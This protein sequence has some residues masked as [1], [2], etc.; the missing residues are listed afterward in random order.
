MFVR[1]EIL[2]K[3]ARD[4]FNPSEKSRPSMKTISGTTPQSST[5]KRTG[6]PGSILLIAYVG[7]ILF[8]LLLGGFSRAEAQDDSFD[9]EK[10]NLDEVKQGELLF[11]H[12]QLATFSKASLLSQ[13]VSISI[14]GMA[15]DVS[16][17]QRFQN[18]TA[19]WLEAI[20]VF[21]LPEQSAVTGMR[22]TIGD[23][24]VV[25]RI[26][27]KELARRTYDQ[28][29]Q[30]GKKTSL[31]VRQRPNIFT[32]AVANI[33][34]GG[35]IEVTMEYVDEL[36]FDNDLFTFRFPMVVGPRYIPGTPVSSG[37]GRI[38]FDGGGWA[39]DT[40]QVQDGSR[41]TPPVVPPHEPARNPVELSLSLAPGFAV[42]DLT[43]LYH[44]V[45]QTKKEK[46]TYH[47]AF[48]GTV[49]ADR[50]FVVQYRAADSK[51]IGAALF[52]DNAAGDHFAYLMLMPPSVQMVQGKSTAPR[53][54][55]FILDISGSMA[56]SSLRQAKSAVQY[57][58]SRLQ[59]RD[60]FNIIV[61]NN[62]ARKLYPDPLQATAQ[63]RTAALRQIAGLQASGGTEM[64][65]ALNLALDGRED[66]GRIRQ[67]VFLTDGAVGNEEA[68]LRLVADRLGDSVLFTVGIGSAPNSYFMRQA[69][70]LGRGGFS[71]IGGVDEVGE[72]M[73]SLLQ[74][75]ENPVITDLK[76]STPH[77]GEIELYPEPLPDI[78]AGQPVVALLRSD[79]PFDILQVSG[80]SLGRRW[81]VEMDGQSG[82]AR[83]GIATLWARKKI[84]TLM[85][86]LHLGVPETEV[87]EQVL[88]TALQ[89]QLVSRYT[90][91]VAVEE[92]VSRPAGEPLQ[93]NQV[94]TN[95]PHGWQYNAVFATAAQT[96]TRAGMSIVL[97][98]SAMLLGIILLL[99]KSVIGVKRRVI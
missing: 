40:D 80:S 5:A 76:I 21:P 31:L 2:A 69:A 39:V 11:A 95:L 97:G 92:I 6:D 29:K 57:G 59:E 10:V 26:E 82:P 42:Q 88:Q 7:T 27:E 87:R 86:G 90:S 13:Q 15:A 94:E 66:R 58:I 14:S 43:S 1:W 45:T 89:H 35:T 60:R 78:Y 67:L 4:F 91:L 96:A 73:T 18:E 32:M 53:E 9:F 99:V 84:S 52:T 55:L 65:S 85:A 46:D 28:A 56:G 24:V 74:K 68:L 98:I 47:L 19:L 22:M 41:I 36:H 79:E 49:Y 8:F 44:G 64:I 16:L 70:L 62:S 83:S 20:Y 23:R 12:H 63:N 93:P 48:D 81:S 54:I 17:T 33:P 75:L 37:E 77:G 3:R 50:D 38:A 51:E 34:P 30:E 25:G 72:K 61:F 71:Y